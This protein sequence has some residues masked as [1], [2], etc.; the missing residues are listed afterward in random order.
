MTLGKVRCLKAAEMELIM[1]RCLRWKAL[2]AEKSDN[3]PGLVSL[4]SKGLYHI[5]IG[6]R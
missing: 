4:T 1:S 2:V 3:N 5:Y 6:S